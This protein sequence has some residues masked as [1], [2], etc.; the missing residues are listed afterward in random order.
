MLQV[1]DQISGLANQINDVS[2][3]LN[4]FG[5]STV[6]KEELHSELDNAIRSTIRHELRELR[7]DLRGSQA[8]IKRNSDSPVPRSHFTSPIPPSGSF[9]GRRHAEAQPDAAYSPAGSNPSDGGRIQGHHVRRTPQ[10]HGPRKYNVALD[11]KLKNFDPLAGQLSIPLEH[12]TAAH[13]LL[14]AWDA[15]HPFYAGI[16]DRDYAQNYVMREE[17]Q[18]GNLRIFGQGEGS[19]G[20]GRSHPATDMP[21]LS[22]RSSFSDIDGSNASTVSSADGNWGI[23]FDGPMVT[24]QDTTGGLNP[25]GNLNLDAV[26]INRLYQSFLQKMWIL[27]PFLNKQHLNK[28][29]ERFVQ[30]YGQNYGA[31]ATTEMR[32]PGEF[33]K[34]QL[35]NSFAFKNTKRKRSDA[36][37]DDKGASPVNRLVGESARNP[38]ERSMNNALL[39]LVFA[40]GRICEHAAPLPPPVGSNYVNASPMTA[41]SPPYTTPLSATTPAFG[42]DSSTPDPMGRSPFSDQSSRSTSKLRNIDKIPGLAYFAYAVGILGEHHGSPDL[43]HVQ[44]SLLAGLY[45][46]QMARVIDSWRWINS[47]CT[48]CQLLFKDERHVNQIHELFLPYSGVS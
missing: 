21:L 11:P 45:L 19:D 13:K 17:T 42:P 10:Q 12:S 7:D 34:P 37:S 20:I 1:M 44:S 25:D 38:L 39:L 6:R 48:D 47:A 9:E 43:V 35:D 23:G 31:Y 2:S 26:T 36:A 4:H 24:A 27:H 3:R 28:M 5:A 8:S 29:F 41:R 46:G 14:I 22:K 16:F 32:S 18:R 30:R 15:I 33:A 40:L